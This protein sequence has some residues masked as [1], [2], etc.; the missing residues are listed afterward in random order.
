MVDFALFAQPVASPT[1]TYVA[2]VQ[3]WQVYNIIM[4]PLTALVVGW[5]GVDMIIQHNKKNKK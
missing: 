5:I 4:C 1:P 3:F 2:P